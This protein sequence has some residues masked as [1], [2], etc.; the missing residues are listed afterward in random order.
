MPI[1]PIVSPIGFNNFPVVFFNV[2]LSILTLVYG[3]GSTLCLID[4][5]YS[6]VQHLYRFES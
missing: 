6:S 3:R 2:L 1:F 5:F 4:M